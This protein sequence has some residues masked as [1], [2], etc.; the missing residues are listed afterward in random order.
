MAGP[1]PL[2]F[3]EAVRR[4]RQEGRSSGSQAT[5]TDTVG[6]TGDVKDWCDWIAESWNRIQMEK[7]G[8]RW[9]FAEV[10]IPVTS[11]AQEYSLGDAFPVAADLARFAHWKPYAFK[12]KVTSEG[13]VGERPLRHRLWQQFIETDFGETQTAQ[14]PS[15]VTIMPNNA[16]RLR[17]LPTEAGTLTARYYK[18]PQALVLAADIPEMPPEFHMLLVWDALLDHAVGELAQEQYARAVDR[19]AALWYQLM[20]RELEPVVNYATT[21]V[22]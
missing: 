3:L 10:A 11:A 9:M 12:Y 21:M 18:A 13:L 19:R 20:N 1:T 22:R 15:S 2:T 8:W 14:R 5:P 17:E 6:Q 16:L 7:Q 4:L